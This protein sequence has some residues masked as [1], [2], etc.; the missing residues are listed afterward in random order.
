MA[1]SVETT[2]NNRFN[3]EELASCRDARPL[4]FSLE[5]SSA[6]LLSSI[7][8]KSM[9]KPALTFDRHRDAKKKLFC[10]I[11]ACLDITYFL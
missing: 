11:T 7:S 10:Q 3:S 2:F 9:S 5:F 6:L 8:F 1:D 4:V